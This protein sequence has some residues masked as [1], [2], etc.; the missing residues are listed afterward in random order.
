MPDVDTPISLATSSSSAPVTQTSACDI[1]FDEEAD[2][3][4]IDQE[5]VGGNETEEKRSVSG[6]DI[7]V[8][9]RISIMNSF[10]VPGSDER[11]GRYANSFAVTAPVRVVNQDEGSFDYHDYLGCFLPIRE[12][13]D[14]FTV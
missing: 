11:R 4:D 8:C 9:E 14:E 6:A 10:P 1:S 12:A 3:E 13:L 2:D 7:N 5:I